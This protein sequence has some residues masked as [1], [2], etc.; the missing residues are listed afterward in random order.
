MGAKMNCI[1]EKHASTMPMVRL[2][3]SKRFVN[4]GTSGTTMPKP[5]RS[6]NTVSQMMRSEGFFIAQILETRNVAGLVVEN[7]GGVY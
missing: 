4:T 5:M 7:M 3:A 1:A 2:L 6:M